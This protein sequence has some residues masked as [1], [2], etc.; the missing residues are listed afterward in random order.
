[1]QELPREREP[2]PARSPPTRPLDGLLVVDFTSIVAGPW[3][4]RLLADCGA[5]VIKIE[6]VGAGDILRYAPPVVD[7]MSRVYAHFNA[8]KQSISLNLKSPSG[9]RLAKQLM[10]RADIVVENFRPGVMRRLG[11]DYETVVERNRRLV[12]CSISGFGQSGA[13]AEKAAYAPIVH[14]YSGFEHVL[15]RAQGGDQTPL[16]GAVMIADFVAASYAFGAIQT[17]LVRRERFGCGSYVDVTLMESMMSLVAIQYQEVQ[18]T[19]A[20]DSRTFPPIKTL[21][22]FMT[23]PLVSLKGYLAIYPLIGHAEWATDSSYATLPGLSERRAEIQAAIVRWAAARSS[24]ECERLLTG[25]GL[26]CSVY[27]APADVLSNPHLRE[28][29]TF[30]EVRD[31][32]GA[33]AVLN[34]PFRVGDAECMVQPTVARVGEHTKSVMTTMLGMTEAEYCQVEAE[35]AFG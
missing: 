20:A 32:A 11:L 13:L 14:A 26:P 28:R 29:G 15:A 8:G 3:C 2:G 10:G 17:A 9:V 1:M 18:A 35:R 31:A 33:F 6:P 12:Y 23:I 19:P 7:G 27:C 5:E 24:E 30:A 34:P 16:T 25:S 4:S 22:G 21:D